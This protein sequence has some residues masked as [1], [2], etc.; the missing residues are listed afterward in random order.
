MRTELVACQGRSM[1][2][3]DRTQ[4]AGRIGPDAVGPETP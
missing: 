4:A 3:T 2:P 1:I